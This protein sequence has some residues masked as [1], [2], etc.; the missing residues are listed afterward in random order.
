MFHWVYTGLVLQIDV[1][2]SPEGEE[3]QFILEFSTGP[4][5]EL[6]PVVCV[7]HLDVVQ[8]HFLVDRVPGGLE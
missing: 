7:I 4:C 6:I 3:S 8:R 1:S 2:H 5:P